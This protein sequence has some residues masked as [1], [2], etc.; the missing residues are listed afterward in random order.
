MYP[1]IQRKARDELDQVVGSDRLPGFEDRES[2]PY[3]QAILMECM[4]YFP[5]V[6]IGVPHRL[7]TDDYYNGYFIPEGTLVIPVRI[8]SFNCNFT[9]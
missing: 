8:W 1:E 6:P 3:V 7:L 2:L 4:R 5:V 9:D